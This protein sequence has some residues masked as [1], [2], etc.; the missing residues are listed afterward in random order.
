MSNCPGCGVSYQRTPIHTIDTLPGLGVAPYCEL[1]DRQLTLGA[2][3]SHITN[4][5]NQWKS[6]D[7]RPEY[8]TVW[9]IALDVA[10]WE[11]YQR[12]GKM[13]TQ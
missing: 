6:K 7:K 1:C 10:D 12:W 2:K 9:Q 13:L 3:K 8:D 4:V 11:H 5:I